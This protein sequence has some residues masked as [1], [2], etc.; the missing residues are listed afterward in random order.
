MPTYLKKKLLLCIFGQAPQHVGSQFPDQG[1]NLYTCT[2]SAILATG[3]PRMPQYLLFM[4]LVLNREKKGLI[5]HARGNN[6]EP[7]QACVHPWQSRK[8]PVSCGPCTK[9]TLQLAASLFQSRGKT[10]S[11]KV[12]SLKCSVF[13]LGTLF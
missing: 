7:Q 4:W 2:G 5:S 11:R 8:G 13:F 1:S 6:T 12:L 10:G 9:L 3:L